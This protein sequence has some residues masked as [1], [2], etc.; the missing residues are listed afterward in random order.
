MAWDPPSETEAATPPARDWAPPTGQDPVA[1]P[2]AHGVGGPV[3]ASLGKRTG[4][5]VIDVLLQV[6][7]F[8]VFSA[9]FGTFETSDDGAEAS[10][11]DAAA[12]GLA[13]VVVVYYFVTEL[14][15][16]ATLGKLALG[17]RVVKE[18]GTKAGA[19]PIALRTVLRIVD[20]I[21]AYL[22]A[23]VTVA[24][25]PKNQRLGDLVAKTLVVEK[26]R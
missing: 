10:V 25:T 6:V 8:G 2:G 18:D 13:L 7:L 23:F 17:L 24:A 21:A 4:A 15:F 20:G 1:G 3:P 19:G 26:D 12:L 16:G 11:E 9:A 22:V 5:G 14:L